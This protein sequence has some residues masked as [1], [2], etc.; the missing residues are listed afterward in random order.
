MM[1][2]VPGSVG[3]TSRAWDEQSLDLTAA[4][5]QIAWA[6]TAGFTEKV[7]AAADRFCRTWRRHTQTAATQCEAHADGLRTVIGDYLATDAAASV[8]FFELHSYLVETR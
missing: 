8:D 1:D 7:Q 2:V 5:K 3:R 4:S 6:A